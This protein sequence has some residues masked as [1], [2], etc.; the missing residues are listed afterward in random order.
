MQVPLLQFS[1][2]VYEND[3]TCKADLIQSA[4]LQHISLNEDVCLYIGKAFVFLPFFSFKHSNEA[5]YLNMRPY[6]T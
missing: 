6:K 1:F 3:L 5:Y 4:W 2:L